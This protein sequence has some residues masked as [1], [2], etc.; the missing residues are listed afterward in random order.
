MKRLLSF[1]VATGLI[2]L[3]GLMSQAQNIDYSAYCIATK[4]KHN[5]DNITDEDGRFSVQISD[6]LDFATW[7]RA[8]DGSGNMNKCLICDGD[9]NTSSGKTCGWNILL[10]NKT[11]VNVTTLRLSFRATDDDATTIVN[12]WWMTDDCT[13]TLTGQDI[14]L[15]TLTPVVNNDIVVGQSTDPIWLVTYRINWNWVS[16]NTPASPAVHVS[17]SC[18]PTYLDAVTS[19]QPLVTWYWQGKNPNGTSTSFVSTTNYTVDS[20]GTYYLRAKG[21]NNNVWSTASSSVNV[22]VKTFSSPA[23]GVNVTNNNTNPGTVK[24]LSVVG[25]SLGTGAVW[26]W[27]GEPACINLKGTGNFIAVDPPA[28]CAY[29]VRAEGDCDTTTTATTTVVVSESGIETSEAFGGMLSFYPNPA[30]GSF[31]VAGQNINES[32]FLSVYNIRGEELGRY[33]LLNGLTE[34]PVH[35]L[36]AGIY[37]LEFRSDTRQAIK[38]LVIE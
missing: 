7:Y 31:T 3:T 12:T 30:H 27:Y 23:T 1:V 5:C 37:I 34:I 18:G 6:N 8:G 33:P 2:L 21:N 25:G 15:S 10:V 4:M 36:A 28:T 26:K 20:T 29:Y 11:N 22:V 16:I 17:P 13:Y 9:A 24:T 32:V 14:L 35:G 19:T 38:K